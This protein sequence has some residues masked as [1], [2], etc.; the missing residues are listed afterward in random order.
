MNLTKLQS[1]LREVQGKLTWAQ[2]RLVALEAEIEEMKSEK[3]I[4]AEEMYKRITNLAQRHTI[5]NEGLK[6]AEL[7]IRAEYISCLSYLALIDKE[8]SEQ[9]LLFLTR[10]ALGLDRSYTTEVVVE[11]GLKFGNKDLGE[12]LMRL[13]DRKLDLILDALILANMGEERK[14]GLSFV[15]DMAYLLG[16]SKEELKVISKVAKAVLE[17]RFD[18]LDEIELTEE[19]SKWQ[20]MYTHYIP[21]KWLISRRA[22]CKKLENVS[23]IKKGL[24]QERYVKKGETVSIGYVSASKWWIPS[25]S[26]KSQEVKLVVPK[27]GLLYYSEKSLESESFYKNIIVYVANIFDDP[28]KVKE[29]ME[30][31]HK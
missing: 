5:S 22:L 19:H 28:S 25:S 24:K 17:N 20:G 18:I 30:K 15:A 10:L 4:D 26:G 16:A 2:N 23:E 31:K 14:M 27:A 13:K 3:Q 1:E 6:K 9:K 11:Y 8:G 21:E 12:S 7:E 29:W